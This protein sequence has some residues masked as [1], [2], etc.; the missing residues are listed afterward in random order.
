[1]SNPLAIDSL[2]A[3]LDSVFNAMKH[4]RSNKQAYDGPGIPQKIW[5]VIF[6]LEKQGHKKSD[7]CRTFGLNSE[8]Y[9]IM[10]GRRSPTVNIS[11]ENK[12]ENIEVKIKKPEA[13]QFGE[14]IC[15][16]NIANKSIPPLVQAAQQTKQVINQLKTSDNQPER[17]LDM[18]T[19]IVECVRPDGHRLKIHTTNDRLD[20]V[21]QCFFNQGVKSL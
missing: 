20:I 12:V 13:V 2:P 11:T 18:T 19:I 10:R 1:M 4:W 9:N 17:Y 6:Q 5:D 7:L 14:A 3:S 15:A 16:D 8:Q 21:M